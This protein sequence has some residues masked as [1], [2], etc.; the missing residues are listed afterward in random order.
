MWNFV[1]CYEISSGLHKYRSSLEKKTFNL[2]IK[3][4][5]LTDDDKVY[6]DGI[7][8]AWREG[9]VHVRQF[10]DLSKQE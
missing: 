2:I 9:N 8:G 10:V 5:L 6:S 7:V 3:M 1:R 4:I